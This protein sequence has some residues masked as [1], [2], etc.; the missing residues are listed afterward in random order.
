M[1]G[2]VIFCG[3]NFWLK[4][5]MCCHS[6]VAVFLEVSLEMSN[7]LI[8]KLKMFHV[9][10]VKCNEKISYNCCTVDNELSSYAKK[11]KVGWR[12]VSGSRT[13]KIGT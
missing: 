3:C 10:S 1:K 7:V 4:K 12:P 9:M 11:K 2:Y 13:V 8:I 5:E 6:L